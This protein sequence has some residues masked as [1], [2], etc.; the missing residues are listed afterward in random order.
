MGFFFL[1]RR[2]F[3]SLF[4]LYIALFIIVL[5]KEGS[6]QRPRMWLESD[7]ACFFSPASPWK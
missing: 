5:F 3:Y 1:K 4:E 6:E 7:L 2:Q